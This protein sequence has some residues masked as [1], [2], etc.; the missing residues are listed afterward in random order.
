MNAASPAIPP[1]AG[2]AP[3]PYA[4]ADILRLVRAYNVEQSG[5]GVPTERGSFGTW[6]PQ[7]S[8]QQFLLERVPVRRKK[9]RQGSDLEVAPIST[10]KG[11]ALAVDGLVGADID[12]WARIGE[13]HGLHA[14]ALDDAAHPSVRFMPRRSDSKIPVGLSSLYVMQGW[15]ELKDRYD[16]V[17][18]GD[19]NYDHYGVVARSGGPMP[20]NHILGVIADHLLTHR[21]EWKP[22]L[23]IARTVAGSGIID[24]VAVYRGCRLHEMPAGAKWFVAGLNAVMLG[25]AAEERAGAT[26][27]VRSGQVWTTNEDGIPTALLSVKIAARAG[28]NAAELNAESG[29]SFN[30]IERSAPSRRTRSQA[31]DRG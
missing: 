19:R 30:R 7:D 29:A 6:G 3:E 22:A 28:R 16:L 26:F 20:S 4:P 9:G 14:A 23:A 8:S 15:T 18:A 21:T 1:D 31:G 13:R 5:P 12:F 2:Y 24:R 25:F 27:L 10:E 17:F 11:T